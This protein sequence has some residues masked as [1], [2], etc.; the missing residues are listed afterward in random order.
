MGEEWWMN[1]LMVDCFWV[2]ELGIEWWY[3][4]GGL[5]GERW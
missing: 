4:V 2:G 1:E 5:I 3:W